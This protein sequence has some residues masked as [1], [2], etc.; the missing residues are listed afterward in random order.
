M[1]EEKSLEIESYRFDTTLLESMAKRLPG[2]TTIPLCSMCKCQ[3]S[4]NCP[5][6]G[7]TVMFTEAKL[8]RPRSITPLAMSSLAWR[9]KRWADKDPSLLS[10]IVQADLG[11]VTFGLQNTIDGIKER[12]F[13][14]LTVYNGSQGITGIKFLPVGLN[15]TSLALGP[16]EKLWYWSW[17][18][19]SGWKKFIQIPFGTWK[20]VRALITSYFVNR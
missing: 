10:A 4:R 14:V 3:Q 9:L 18:S 1:K 7:V 2:L 20:N 19:W 15:G 6:Y 12:T 5:R 11:R 13:R 8:L 17:P 16:N